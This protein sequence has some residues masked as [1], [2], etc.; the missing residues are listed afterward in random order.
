MSQRGMFH[1]SCIHDYELSVLQ[2]SSYVL[3]ICWCGHTLGRMPR[4][5]QLHLEDQ[6]WPP[7]SPIRWEDATPVDPS[8]PW[9][10]ATILHCVCDL[11]GKVY[12]AISS[13]NGIQNGGPQPSQ[14]MRIIRVTN[15]L[16]SRLLKTLHQVGMRDVSFPVA[17]RVLLPSVLRVWADD[18]VPRDLP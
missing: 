8:F 18:E 17:C 4:E 9:A 15:Q 7:V 6:V 3:F 1:R 5:G 12:E 16:E 11:P 2:G 10:D 13:S 14:A